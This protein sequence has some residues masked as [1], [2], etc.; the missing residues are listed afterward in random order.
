M[1]E[2]PAGAAFHLFVRTFIDF[3]AHVRI[4]VGVQLSQAQILSA[5]SIAPQ[6]LPHHPLAHRLLVS[7]TSCLVR[8]FFCKGRWFCF[9]TR[10]KYFERI[11][12]DSADVEPK[13]LWVES[14]TKLHTFSRL[15]F[16]CCSG[17]VCMMRCTACSNNNV[18][19]TPRCL[20]L[21]TVSGVP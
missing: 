9:F 5:H 14:K 20:K 11:D 1:G 4:S 6:L 17:L 7:S 15:F 18:M 2:P 16:E 13:Q 3:F 10:H 19:E 12:D 8:P 21:S